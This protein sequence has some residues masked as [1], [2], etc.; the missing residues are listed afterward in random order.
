MSVADSLADFQRYLRDA[1]LSEASINS[2]MVGV[3]KIE[4][5]YGDLA[6]HYQSDGLATVLAELEYSS[7]DVRHNRPNPSK[8]HIPTDLIKNLSNYR[9]HLRKYIAFL[10]YGRDQSFTLPTPTAQPASLDSKLT[11]ER[12]MQLALRQNIEALEPGLQIIDAGNERQVAT[13]RIDL[14]CTDRSNRTVIIE[15]KAGK[16]DDRAITQLMGYMGDL[17]E[18]NGVSPRGI[19]IAHDFTERTRSAARM[20]PDIQLKTYQVRFSFADAE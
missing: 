11:L 3:R 4:T 17:R 13:G 15:L 12:D 18:E 5:A 6:A 19:L 20:I 1:G 8:I 9:S 2:Y 14:T 7:D 16:A 10:E